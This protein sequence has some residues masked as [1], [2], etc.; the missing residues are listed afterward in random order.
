[1]SVGKA[2]IELL[3]SRNAAIADRA[4]AANEAGR[5]DVAMLLAATALP[6]EPSWIDR[7]DPVAEAQAVRAL[8]GQRVEEM[9]PSGGAT[10]SAW[11]PTR[12]RLFLA[13][14]GSDATAVDVGP[15]IRPTAWHADASGVT[16]LAV[17]R[18]GK[19]VALAVPNGIIVA[20]ASTGAVLHR[21]PTSASP[22]RA[23][24]FSP[25]GERL[26]VGRQD[27][28]AQVW[29]IGA[30]SWGASAPLQANWP[31]AGIAFS[32]DGSRVLSAV[33]PTC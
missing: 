2:A 11:S 27:G 17:S 18:D 26:A 24:A 4:R 3:A 33:N 15:S 23:L 7:S 29:R 6:V 16:Q 22:G 9:Y 12:S 32:L 19:L 31:V 10:L 25:D 5:S 21:A 28:G 14:Y 30:P 13:A 8:L 20:D 1:M